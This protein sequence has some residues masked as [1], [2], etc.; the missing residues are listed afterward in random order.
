MRSSRSRPD[1]GRLGESAELC[2]QQAVAAAR[3]LGSVT[4]EL[5]AARRLAR[6][7]QIQGDVDAP[8]RMLEPL[9]ARIDGGQG[10]R[11]VEAAIAAIAGNPEGNE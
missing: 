11:E 5:A 6:L 3:A 10:V 4:A 7:L 8:R 9:L 1:S 2:Y